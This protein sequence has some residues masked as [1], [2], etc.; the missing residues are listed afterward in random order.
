MENNING[1]SS[2]NDVSIK[3]QAAGKKKL[4]KSVVIIGA[5]IGIILGIF[6][7]IVITFSRND[8]VC[9][10]KTKEDGFVIKEVYSFELDDNKGITKI[11]KKIIYSFSKEI[12]DDNYNSFV[13]RIGANGISEF[14]WG[15]RVTRGK[16]TVTVSA[17]VPKEGKEKWIDVKGVYQK[18]GYKCN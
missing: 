4:K 15:T 9:T 11:N 10:K 16:K 5:I 12:S 1:V 18:S 8:A 3:K 2:V 6:I 17:Y 7:V 13:S 14:G